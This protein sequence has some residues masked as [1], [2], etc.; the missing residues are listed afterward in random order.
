MAIFSNKVHIR[1]VCANGSVVIGNGNVVING[2]NISSGNYKTY[3]K[4]ESI[5]SVGVSKLA[6]RCTQVNVELVEGRLDN[7]IISAHLSGKGLLNKE[8]V[9]TLKDV[10]GK[11]YID[12]DVGES[13]VGNLKLTITVPKYCGFYSIEFDGYNGDFN[14]GKN[15]KG[16]YIETKNYNGDT[17]I[18]CGFYGLE[19]ESYNGDIDIN[20]TAECDMSI[21][22]SSYNGDIDVKIT[23]ISRYEIAS[24]SE[25]GDVS[26][27]CKGNGNYKVT[28]TVSSYNGDVTLK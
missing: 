6:I 26:R 9:L 7:H 4:E 1:N 25:N 16:D 18:E 27:R 12:L 8:P 15:V 22:A 20:A 5:S 14:I 13:G 24:K 3:D 10:N 17:N 23:N 11:V 21:K 28:G 2:Q 19:A